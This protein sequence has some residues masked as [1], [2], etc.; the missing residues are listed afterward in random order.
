MQGLLPYPINAIIPSG[1]DAQKLTIIP[2]LNSQKEIY[3][4]SVRNA[5]RF[6]ETIVPLLVF[7]LKT[8]IINEFSIEVIRQRDWVNVFGNMLEPA[9][10]RIKNFHG[11]ILSYQE[12][13]FF[14]S[15]LHSINESI[16]L[17][18]NGCQKFPME[19]LIEDPAILNAKLLRIRDLPNK[20]A[21]WKLAEKWIENDS[22][23]GTTF[24]VTSTN[25]HTFHQFAV[26]FKDRLISETNEEILIK[27]D[28]PSKHILLKLARRCRVSRPLICIVVS[29][30]TKELEFETS[31]K[32][33][34]KKMMPLSEYLSFLFVEDMN[35]EDDLNGSSFI[36]L[37]LHCVWLLITM[38][39]KCLFGRN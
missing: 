25:H 28:N 11:V 10:F 1:Y 16:H 2:S 31:G 30:E 6:T 4:I 32:W 37:M 20:D 13:M 3:V 35:E 39:L 9:S 12:T 15:K 27:T 18:A 19:R 22:P 24:R 8:S 23:I 14:V 36:I 21:V 17:D 33:V 5:I 34:T 38:I 7:I 26:V 29:S